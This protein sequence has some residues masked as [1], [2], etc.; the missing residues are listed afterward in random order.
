MLIV[1]TN[2]AWVGLNSFSILDAFDFAGLASGG[3]SRIPSQRRYAFSQRTYILFSVA[4]M[5]TEHLCSH[6]ESRDLNKKY[7]TQ[8]WHS[9]A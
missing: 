4:T 3:G 7:S 2:I 5:S 1:F 6:L 8:V 9:R